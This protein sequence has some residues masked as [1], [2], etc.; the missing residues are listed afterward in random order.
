M[1]RS[2]AEAGST[3]HH[4][5]PVDKVTTTVAAAAPTT[6]VTTRQYWKSRL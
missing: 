1:T 6:T 3:T 5:R 2:A 4:L